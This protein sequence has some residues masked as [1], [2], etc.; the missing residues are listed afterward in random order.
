MTRAPTYV[1]VADVASTKRRTS[2]VYSCGT[3]GWT[4]SWPAAST[5]TAGGSPN[6]SPLDVIV[7]PLLAPGAAS[8]HRTATPMLSGGKMRLALVRRPPG[9]LV[10]TLLGAA[11]ACTSAR[12]ARA[13]TSA[14]TGQVT[15]ARTGQG[16][17]GVAVEVQGTQLAANTR[18]DGRF[19]FGAVPR[20]SY[21]VIARRI[22]YASARQQIT[23]GG[24]DVTVNFALQPAAVSLDQVVVT[25]TAGAQERRTI[26]NSVSTINA[27]D[28][29]LASAAPDITSL[30][31]GRAP[32]VSIA[33]TTGR[34]GAGPDI[35]IRGRSSLSLNNGPLIY[36]DGVRVDNDTHSGPVGV[37]GVGSSFG[38]QNSNVAGRL[39]DISPDDIETIEIIKGPAAST[40][41]GTEA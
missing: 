31:N 26:A 2:P 3:P 29:K 15:D 38:G 8:R 19:R 27:P 39:N 18:D 28:V 16:V 25:G 35:Q 7:S 10:A 40:I 9:W 11:L 14:V 23:S 34:L 6:A 21:T 17:A 20:G 5:R 41:Y 1:R 13:Q 12:G 30:L 37:S 33:A 24:G 22:G 32:G 4:V 36:I